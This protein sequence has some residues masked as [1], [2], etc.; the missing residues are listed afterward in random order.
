MA[1]YGTLEP[2]N[3]SSCFSVALESA[4]SVDGRWILFVSATPGP[5]NLVFRL[6]GVV[7]AEYPYL[8]SVLLQ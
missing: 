6:I 1:V 5:I 4:A 8:T 3:C 2:P 7:P